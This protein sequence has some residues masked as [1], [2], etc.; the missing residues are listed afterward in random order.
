[1]ATVTYMHAFSR[2]MF[3]IHNPFT[4]IWY[5][6]MRSMHCYNKINTKPCTKSLKFSGLVIEFWCYT[7]ATY[8]K[9]LRFMYLVES[10][11]KAHSAGCSIR[12]IC[13]RLI[14]SLVVVEHENA[15]IS[16]V[17]PQWKYSSSN[18]ALLCVLHYIPV[19]VTHFFNNLKRNLTLSKYTN[20]RYIWLAGAV[21]AHNGW[22]WFNIN[23]H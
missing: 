21:R 2:N 1:M 14:R 9:W 4:T 19:G 5:P 15:S 7:S 22:Q 17:R 6:C 3:G 12:S 13:K 10:M 8:A 11:L 18:C 16:P 20:T 23:K